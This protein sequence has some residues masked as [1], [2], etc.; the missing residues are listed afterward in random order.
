MSITSMECSINEF[1]LIKVSSNGGKYIFMPLNIFQGV[2]EKVTSES[3]T[4]T[5]IRV[6]CILEL[7][8]LQ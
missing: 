5:N 4:K 6:L 8:Q 3:T 7:M 1:N 2:K